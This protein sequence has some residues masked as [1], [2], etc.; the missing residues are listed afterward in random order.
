MAVSR[1]QLA[2][3]IPCLGHARELE[4]CLYGLQT[5]S[6]QLP[7]EIIVVDSAYDEDVALTAQKFK[8]VRLVR[9]RVRLSAGAARN[10]GVGS[11]HAEWIA[12]LDADCIPDPDWVGQARE[13]LQAGYLFCG[14]PVLDLY[15][16]HPVA[17]VDNHLQFADFQAA[18]PAGKA[19]YFPACNLILPRSTFIELG[20]FGEDHLSGED[21]L[22]SQAA[23][24]NFPDDIFFN[25]LLVVR[26]HGRKEIPGLL[27][28]QKLMGYRRAKGHLQ[29]DASYEWLARH[30][31]LAGLV[32]FRRLGYIF[33]RTFQFDSKDL[34][35][36]L[37]F[38]PWLTV[39][40]AAWTRG[41][42]QG[43]RERI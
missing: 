3:I 40:L 14:G 16:N 12:F 42:Y 18:R 32:I 20:G 2:V 43:A 5:Q 19:G 22:L 17:W 36:L 41:F 1:E 31:W 7:F 37:V 30:P 33:L 24:L 39:G 29:M 8:Q 35:R 26:H 15:P 9:S 34:I 23:D 27:E 28:H 25:P 13:S 11:T 4:S 21:G 38:L 10:L 6:G